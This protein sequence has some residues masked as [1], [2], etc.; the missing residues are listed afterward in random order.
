MILEGK[1]YEKDTDLHD[2]SDI[3]NFPAL[4]SYLFPIE[5]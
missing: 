1:K 4:F 2:F 5:K 3:S